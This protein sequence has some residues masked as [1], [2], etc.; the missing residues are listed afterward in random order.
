MKRSKGMHREDIKAAVRKKGATL[1]QLSL[2]AGLEVK[3]A[4]KSLMVP[5]PRANRAI[6]EFLGKSLHDLWPHWYSQN[7]E[8]IRS[9]AP[10]KRT[11]NTPRRHRQKSPSQFA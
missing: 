6:A 7:G 10:L 2:Q 1:Q 4:S 9:Q 11:R 3:T 5:C 8:R